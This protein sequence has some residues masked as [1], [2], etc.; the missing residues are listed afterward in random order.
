MLG[1]CWPASFFCKVS[2]KFLCL[3]LLT[4]VRAVKLPAQLSHLASCSSL[5][6]TAECPHQVMS[7]KSSTPCDSRNWDSSQQCL[8]EQTEPQVGTGPRSI[9]GSQSGRCD[10]VGKDMTKRLLLQGQIDV[11]GE[12]Q[13]RLFLCDVVLHAFKTCELTHWKQ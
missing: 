10:R 13:Q 3:S 6:R 11:C 4:A 7:S 2:Q 9:W 1:L 5:W 8:K 12:G